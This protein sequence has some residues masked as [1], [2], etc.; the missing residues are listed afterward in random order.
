[1]TPEEHDAKL[2]EQ[3]K[4]IARR[5]EDLIAER[6]EH[7]TELDKVKAAVRI[8]GP[9]ASAIYKQY[10]DAQEKHVA[11]IARID[12]ALRPLRKEQRELAVRRWTDRQVSMEV[13]LVETYALKRV[14]QALVKLRSDLHNFAA[15]YTRSPTMR[16][17]NAQFAERVDEIIQI[18]L[19]KNGASS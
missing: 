5:Q 14:V 19:D 18:A 17:S 16:L 4:A 9:M 15:D 2:Q 1:M 10:C 6:K 12:E 13:K 7:Q 3:E 11:A 8:R